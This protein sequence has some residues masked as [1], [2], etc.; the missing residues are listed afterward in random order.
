MCVCG[1]LHCTLNTANFENHACKLEKAI[2]L[3]KKKIELF[4]ERLATQVEVLKSIC[5]ALLLFRFLEL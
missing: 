3:V 4:K 2:L 1:A 5:S